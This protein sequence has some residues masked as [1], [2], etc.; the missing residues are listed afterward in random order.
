[1]DSVRLVKILQIIVLYA[2]D[3][4]ETLLQIVPAWTGIIMMVN[5]ITV[6]QMEV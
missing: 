6:L 3:K 5:F 1:M 4:I 2:K